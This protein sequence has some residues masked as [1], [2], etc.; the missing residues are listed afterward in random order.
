MSEGVSASAEQTEETKQNAVSPISPAVPPKDLSLNLDLYNFDTP[1]AQ[2]CP[3]VLT[4]PRSLEACSRVGIKVK[5]GLLWF[6]TFIMYGDIVIFNLW[7]YGST[8]KEMFQ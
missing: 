7:Q 6:L 3:Y 4:S 5:T 2:S 8:E 1:D